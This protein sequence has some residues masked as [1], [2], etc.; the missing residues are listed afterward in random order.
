M[1]TTAHKGALN[2]GTVAVLGGGVDV[3]CTKKNKKLF[4]NLVQSGVVVSEMPPGTKPIARHFPQR[5]RIISG[6]SRGGRR[7]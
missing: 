1:D 4:D 7:R 5:N 2:S 3:V 6:I